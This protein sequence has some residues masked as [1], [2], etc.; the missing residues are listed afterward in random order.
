LDIDDLLTR[1]RH[2]SIGGQQIPTLR[3]DDL[4]VFL[5]VHGARH[6]W[7]ELRWVCDLAQMIRSR[8][9]LDW[10]AIV[11]RSRETGSERMVFVAGELVR[12]LLGVSN[13]LPAPPPVTQLARLFI[14]RLLSMTPRPS[15]SINDNLLETR[16]TGSYWRRCRYVIG[17]LTT[18]TE[19]EWRAGRLPRV[20]FPVYYMV[21]PLRLAFKHTTRVA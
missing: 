10:D 20:L 19:A 13:P 1:I 15:S 3:D 6:L 4:F 8:P 9:A 2:V 17:S 5:A 21:R 12:T 11:S 14:A 16:L 18:P 7:S